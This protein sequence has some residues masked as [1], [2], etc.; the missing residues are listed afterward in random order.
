MILV[1]L[2]AGCRR[3]PQPETS[4]SAPVTQAPETKEPQ[5][6][7][8]ETT[9]PETEPVPA[10]LGEVKGFS[11][12]GIHGETSPVR[13]PDRRA[14]VIARLERRARVGDEYIRQVEVFPGDASRV[15]VAFG[16]GQYPLTQDYVGE[17]DRTRYGVF[18]LDPVRGARSDTLWMPECDSGFFDRIGTDLFFRC[19][20]FPFF[21]ENGEVE[22]PTMRHLTIYGPDLE[23]RR[24][25][26][27]GE[28]LLVFSPD[29]KRSYSLEGDTIL[30]RSV[31]EDK[32]PEKVKLARPFMPKYLSGVG[33]I[34]GHDVIFCSGR[35]GDLQDYEAAISTASGDFLIL[36]RA[37]E[38]GGYFY[39]EGAAVCFSGF[40]GEEEASLDALISFREGTG[41][42]L[43]CGEPDIGISSRV[44]P[45]EKISVAWALPPED[46]E[47]VGTLLNFAVFDGRSGK[48]VAA[49]KITVP[50]T[51]AFI[52]ETPL[53][54]ESERCWLA[55]FSAGDTELGVLRIEEGGSNL[56]FPEL[57]VT[58]ES[59]PENIV[60]DVDDNFAVEDVTP[61]P[62]PAELSHL[63]ARA[64]ALGDTYG[65]RIFISDQCRN[66][67][68]GY[69]CRPLNDETAIRQALDALEQELK[70]YPKGFFR[71]LGTTVEWITGADL[72]VAGT[73]MGVSDNDG[74]LDFA[75][76]FQM[77]MDGRLML[78]MDSGDPDS[79]RQTF[80]H[81]LCHAIESVMDFSVKG[82]K[83]EEWDALNPKG[84]DCYS[85]SY[86]DW[87]TE[88]AVPYQYW[89]GGE[90]V[91]ERAY[92][93]DTYSCTFPTEDRARLF[94]Y[95]MTDSVIPWKK[96][97]HLREKLRLF[98]DRMEKAL[99]ISG[100][101]AIWRK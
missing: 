49:A 83:P 7:S 41:V 8:P 76:G 74:V 24:V 38:R 37:N 87:G 98:T 95:A 5:S 1:C 72:Y 36:R 17:E 51:E 61:G 67:V 79:L 77:T 68:G 42:H 18:V 60:A 32:A 33:S 30:C 78:Y 71:K 20:N 92:F 35:A 100:E 48:Q 64:K 80:H 6:T 22:T 86:Q 11:W 85:N 21:G 73:L 15:R 44:L 40:A 34:G 14:V 56:Y 23:E 53:Y 19:T 94:E 69:L 96:C 81:E 84:V 9:V 99:N 62:V 45:G 58:R 63:E 39:P 29:G 97:P 91:P 89:G 13:S 52:T 50:Y 47:Q 57:T 27:E 43:F 93:I 70:K 54:L 82:I 16:L 46:P 25:L 88:A 59:W 90:S 2:A 12:Y 31:A 65:I 28:D 26:S 75:G 55:F 4:A 66:Y 101:G 10:F 3:A